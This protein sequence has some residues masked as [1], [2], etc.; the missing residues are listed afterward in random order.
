MS[1][2]IGLLVVLLLVCLALLA[3]YGLLRGRVKARREVRTR[4]MATPIG[5][6]ING[7]ARGTTWTGAADMAGGEPE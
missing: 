1:D 7:S 6:T 5:W 2:P 3:G 4:T